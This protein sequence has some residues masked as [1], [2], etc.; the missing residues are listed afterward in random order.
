M[1][2]MTPHPATLVHN[3]LP[4][5]AALYEQGLIPLRR[6]KDIEICHDGWCDYISGGWC[7][8]DPVVSIPGAQFGAQASA[9]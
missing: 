3:Y 5:L 7:N 2:R 6:W 4:K 8:C 9:G 1:K